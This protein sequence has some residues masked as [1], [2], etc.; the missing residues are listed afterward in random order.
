MDAPQTFQPDLFYEPEFSQNSDV[1]VKQASSP[2]GPE[3]KESVKSVPEFSPVDFSQEEKPSG[4]VSK[5]VSE[6]FQPTLIAPSFISGSGTIPG[7]IIR[8]N[9][10]PPTAGRTAF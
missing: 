6:E 5:E 8:V 4:E 7:N 1:E 9:R 10:R 2:L 3:S